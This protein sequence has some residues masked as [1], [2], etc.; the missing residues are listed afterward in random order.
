MQVQKIFMLTQHSKWFPIS[1]ACKFLI[2]SLGFIV[3]LRGCLCRG[4]WGL[5]ARIR[6]GFSNSCAGHME[7][8]MQVRV[9]VEC[10]GWTTLILATNHFWPSSFAGIFCSL[11][12]FTVSK[13]PTGNH[14][15]E[16]ITEHAQYPFFIQIC[17]AWLNSTFNIFIHT[18][19][20][21]CMYHSGFC[22]CFAL[23]DHGTVVELVTHWVHALV[24]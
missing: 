16:S 14:W 1:S 4:R 17:Q 6:V 9:Q 23:F 18:Y 7:V 15:F 8:H 20:R 10:S 13:N 22:F 24:L 5:E 12:A 2:L 19:T 21:T 3:L 11:L